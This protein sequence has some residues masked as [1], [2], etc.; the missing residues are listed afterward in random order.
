MKKGTF[1]ACLVIAICIIIG[2]MISSCSA[3]SHK[4]IKS[5][6]YYYMFATG[7]FMAYNNTL[8]GKMKTY[9]EFK[10]QWTKDSLWVR[11][12]IVKLH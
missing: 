8:E 5:E 2:T 11:N 9:P 4:E 10:A 3:P 1:Q 12:L 6:S 7:Y